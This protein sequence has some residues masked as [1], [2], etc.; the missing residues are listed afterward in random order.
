M[1]NG[2]LIVIEGGDGSGKT[3]QAKL[4]IKYLK[5]YDNRVKYMDFPQYKSFYG[6]TVAKFLRG[7][8]GAIDQVSPYLASLA[9]ALDRAA[10]KNEMEEFL[11]KGGYIIANRYATSNMAH[12]GAKFKDSISQSDFLNWVYELEYKIHRIPKENIV[13]YLYV[14]WQ[15]AVTLTRQKGERQY[16]LGKTKDIH[17]KDDSH[18]IAAEKMYIKLARKYKHWVTIDCIE[19]SKILSTAIISEKIINTLKQKR[20]I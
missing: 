12:Q 10:V 1:K 4:L 8:F 6:K 11:E 15:I 17:E 5:K 16:L 18:R 2:K 3:T 13:I 7:E 14:P 19:N 20:V 9:Y